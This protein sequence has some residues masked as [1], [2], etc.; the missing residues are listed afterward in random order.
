MMAMLAP[1]LSRGAL[2][3]VLSAGVVLCSVWGAAVVTSV[4]AAAPAS[5]HV[6][7]VKITP[8]S[9]AQL[10]SAPADGEQEFIATFITACS[11]LD[12]CTLDV[13]NDPHTQHPRRTP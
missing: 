2:A 13:V 10:T 4:I 12:V 3:T 8:D 5:A 6:V 9:D 7:L 1:S 11:T